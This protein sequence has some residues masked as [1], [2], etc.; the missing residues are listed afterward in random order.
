MTEGTWEEQLARSA[1]EPLEQLELYALATIGER[2]LIDPLTKRLS[3][4]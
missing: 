4:F 3:L 2:A 1:E